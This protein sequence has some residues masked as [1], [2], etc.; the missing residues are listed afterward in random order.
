MFVPRNDVESKVN[1]T[2]FCSED[3]AF[4]LKSLFVNYFF[5]RT[6]ADAVLLCSFEPSVRMCKS[7]GSCNTI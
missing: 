4:H 2:Y 1:S 6:A 7:S 3:G 5:F